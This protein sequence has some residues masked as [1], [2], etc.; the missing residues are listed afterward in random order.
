MSS[1]PYSRDAFSGEIR[2]DILRAS[3]SEAEKRIQALG[4]AV[5]WVGHSLREKC[6][7]DRGR[8][9]KPKRSRRDVLILRVKGNV[10]VGGG[11]M[12]ATR[13]L[14][15][16]SHTHLRRWKVR[17]WRVT[18]CW[19]GPVAGVGSTACY[20]CK[21]LDLIKYPFKLYYV[22]ITF[23]IFM[24]ILSKKKKKFQRWVLS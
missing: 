8:G 23:L 9:E 7:R 5:F 4:C 24:G 18:S 17:T 16:R 21:V 2:S 20:T 14:G 19:R 6:E 22:T 11:I 13:S 1:V 15:T 3:S 12:R 10:T